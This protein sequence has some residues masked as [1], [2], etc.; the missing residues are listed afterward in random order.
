MQNKTVL[1]LK[2]EESTGSGTKSYR[3]ISKCISGI[4][5]RCTKPGSRQDA[6]EL[7]FSPDFKQCIMLPN[8]FTRHDGKLTT[9]ALHELYRNRIGTGNDVNIIMFSTVNSYML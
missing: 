8:T 3:L 9:F 2:H 5:V 4:Q 7:G 6:E 1:N